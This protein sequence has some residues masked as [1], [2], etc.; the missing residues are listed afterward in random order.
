MAAANPGKWVILVCGR[1]G[2]GTGALLEMLASLGH[3][4]F[5]AA[6]LAHRLAQRGTPLHHQILDRVGPECLTPSGELDPFQLNQAAR[7]D[8][9]LAQDLRIFT[10]LAVKTEIQHRIQ[11]ASGNLVFVRTHSLEAYGARD[12]ADQVWLVDADEAV[13]VTNLVREKGWPRAVAERFVRSQPP[14]RHDIHPPDLVLHSELSRSALWEKLTAALR[15]LAGKYVPLEARP[16]VSLVAIPPPSGNPPAAPD[17]SGPHVT[18]PQSAKPIAGDFGREMPPSGLSAPS[19]TSVELKRIGRRLLDS[20]LVLLSIAFLTSWGL[21][22]AQSGRQGLPAQPLAAAWQGLVA[23]EQFFVAHPQTYVWARTQIPWFQLVAQVLGRSATLLV[24][25][26]GV[27]LLIGFPLGIAAARTRQ[28]STSALTVIFSVLGASIPSF[29]FAMIL[30]VVNIWVHQVTGMRVLP[31]TG[32]GWDGHLIMPTLALAMRPLAQIAQITYV[33][34]REALQ[35]DYVRTAYSKGL[36]WRAVL[37]KHLLRN[38][39][40]PILNTLGS[41]LRF[42]LSSLPI[43]EV[44]FRWPGVGSALLDA[45]QAGTAPLV[46]DLTLSLGLFFLVVNLLLEFFFPLIDPR[47]RAEVGSELRDKPQPLQEWLR[48][49]GG[50]LAA[51]MRELFQRGKPR[52]EALPPLIG[53]A[54][55]NLAPPD[56][57][58]VSRAKSLLGSLLRNPVLIL[59]TIMIA[60]LTL[61]ALFGQNLEAANAYKVHG[62][63]AIDGAYAAPPFQPSSTFPWGTDQIGRDIQALLLAG[64][65]R[66]LSLAFFGMLARL[67]VGVTLGLL[68]GWHKGAWIDRLVSGAIGTW[69]AFPATIFAMLAIQALGIQQGMWVFVVAIS[70][71]GWGEVAQFVRG[72]VNALAAQPY[73]ESARSIGARVERILTHH[74]FPN[75][76]NP[77]VVLA[78]LE[79]GAILMLLAELGYLNIFLGGGFRVMTGESGSAAPII[80]YYSDVPEWSALIANVRDQWRSHT[81][82]ALYPG[83]AVFLAIISFN[84]FGEGLRHFL[85]DSSISLSRWFNRRSLVVAATL[86]SVL[87]LAVGSSSPL[88]TYRPE[89]PK[90]DER[91]VLEDIRIL[92][93]P[94][95]QGRETGTPGAD[96]AALYIAQRMAQIG[97]FPAGEHNSYYQRSVQPRLHLLGIPSLALLDD[98]GHAV[99]EFTYRRD[100]SELSILVQ[101]RGQAQGSVMG[102]AYGPNLE[103]GSN[104]DFG[105]GNSAAIDHVILVRAADLSKVISRPVAAVLVIVD[106]AE[107]LERRLPYPLGSRRGDAELPFLQISEH[108]ADLLLKTAGS[109]LKELDAARMSLAPGKIQLTAQGQA[110]AISLQAGESGNPMDEA[111]LN[112][113]GVIPGQ[114]HFVGLEDQI[115]VVSAYY[116]GPGTDPQGILFPGANDNASGTAMLLELARLLK[117]SPYQ[118]D[119]TVLFVAWPGGER[120]EGLSTSDILNARPGANRM[121]VEAVIELSGVGSGTGSSVAIGNDSSYRLVQLFQKAAGRYGI[122]TTTRG[123]GPHFGL[124]APSVLGGRDALTLSLSWDGSDRLAH[125]PQD[126]AA[127]IDPAK[128]GAVGQPAYLTLLVLS[129]ETEY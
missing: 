126:T 94:E 87:L 42:S 93:S 75:L 70:L 45:I 58:P 74:I 27:A 79:M 37:N 40:I 120:Q 35:Q 32:F 41:S 48:E 11:S 88:N 81:W 46:M 67:C 106:D 55:A 47:L 56:N 66:T 8:P 19:F 122:P 5:D 97:I 91:K 31:A 54:H 82:M 22:L 90:F 107:T 72:Q 92:S 89:G 2:T 96:L 84:L 77:L 24:L 1:L 99:K 104:A 78:A 23:V 129:R 123:R 26:M 114:G 33:T 102:V 118:P 17:G 38:V 52:S 9:Q 115:I 76:V 60:T 80:A 112:V 15:G 62:V 71:V 3:T 113:I 36:A 7:A 117:S 44:F 43:V 28:K 57:P 103:A 49:T 100:F 10:S 51:W 85:E 14:L 65:R 95:M 64:A 128:L 73:I 109:S 111:Y 61:I 86:C 125:L 83:L 50:G 59:A 110:V 121:T 39:L 108:V 127:T 105:L 6:D 98:S 20:A 16:A 4:T 124:P 53:T 63:M 29:L 119:K 69:A 13:Q 34:L 116:D 25:S 68:A 18:L 12:L 30:W 21:A 101:S